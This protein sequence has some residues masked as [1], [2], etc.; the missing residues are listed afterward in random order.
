MTQAIQKKPDYLMVVPDAVRLNRAAVEEISTAADATIRD[1]GRFTLVLSGGNTPAPVYALWA[2][3][4][5]TTLPWEKVYIFFGDERH[6]PPDHPESNYRMAHDSLLSRV[7][8]PQSNVFR[9]KAE[10]PAERAAEDYEAAIRGFFRLQKGEWPRFDLILLGMGDDGHTA[11][12]FPGTPA[13]GETSRLVVANPVVKFQTERITMTLPVLNHAAEV[14]FMVAGE[15][16]APVM[17]EIF[18]NHAHDLYPSQRV[19]PENGRLLWIAD[20]AAAQLL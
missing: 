19:H 13:L 6:V 14:L 17:A 5:K 1:H 16:K 12:L 8:I 7:P 9:V 15:T 18:R 20:Q 3:E 10:N 4:R 2:E 11:S